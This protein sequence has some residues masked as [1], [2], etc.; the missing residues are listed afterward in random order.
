MTMTT[1]VQTLLTQNGISYDVLPHRKTG[2]S[3]NSALSSHVTAN[4]VAKSVI[5]EDRLGYL[6]AVIPANKHVKI[7]KLNKVLDRN[8]MLACEDELKDLFT[9]CDIGAIPPF[10][11]VYHMQSI[12]DEDL[13]HCSD[14]YFEAGNHEEL[15]HV[16][17]SDFRRLMQGAPHTSISLH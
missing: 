13:L 11:S 14:I 2:T 4:M 17:G 12:I 1:T 8:M 5:L 10:G 6:M 16:K 15:I 9:D 3:V 7:A